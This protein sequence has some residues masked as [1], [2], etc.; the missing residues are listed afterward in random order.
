L[1]GVTGG[2]GVDI[3]DVEPLGVGVKAV[4]ERLDEDFMGFVSG[5]G[6]TD[7]EC[8]VLSELTDMGSS[9]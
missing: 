4:G 2:G 9:R 3:F 1:E 6:D 7:N 5:G 8:K